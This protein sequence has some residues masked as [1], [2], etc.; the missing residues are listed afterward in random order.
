VSSRFL[1]LEPVVSWPREARFGGRYELT[2][3]LRTPAGPGHWPFEEEE[4]EFSCLLDA[5]PLF[6]SRPVDEP[7]LILHRFGGT[8]GP[9]RF[10]LTAVSPASGS[11]D[12][13][14]RSA[15]IWLTYV[16]RWGVP[17]RTVELPVRF[18]HGSGPEPAPLSPRTGA[19]PHDSSAVPASPAAADPALAA[20]ESSA[21]G[22]GQDAEAAEV[23]RRVLV[24]HGRDSQVNARFYDLLHAVDLEPLEWEILVEATGS[25]APHLG[26]VVA[27]APHL[28]QAALVLLSPDDIVEL[29][30]DLFQDSDPPAERAR[31]GQARPNVLIE[32]GLVLGTYPERTIVV[33]VGQMR[34]VADLAG[35]NV[36]RFDGSA[37]AIKKLLDRLRQAGCQVDTAGTGWLD[38]RFAGLAALAVEP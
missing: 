5:Q 4:F 19:L 7:T 24:V 18:M 9:V 20:E 13:D 15:S 23:T 16:N 32:L 25:T 11:A 30:S 37:V 1:L 14:V 6:I 34:P 12:G 27:R 29:H 17:I 8:Y 21:S 33:E 28:A 22:I 26:Q 10:E 2:A 3:D 35:L 38:D 31:A 36:I